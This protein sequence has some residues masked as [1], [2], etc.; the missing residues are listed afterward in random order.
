MAGDKPLAEELFNKATGEKMV[1]MVGPTKTHVLA[2]HGGLRLEGEAVVLGGFCASP[3]LKT[4]TIESLSEPLLNPS[5]S[6]DDLKVMVPDLEKMLEAE[7]PTELKAMRGEDKQV[8]VKPLKSMTIAFLWEPTQLKACSNIISTGSP[9]E[10]MSNLVQAVRDI[11]DEREMEEQEQDFWE[12]AIQH[13]WIQV[14]KFAHQFKLKNQV[15]GDTA[16]DLHCMD[17][18]KKMHHNQAEQASFEVQSNCNNN[19]DPG[20]SEGGRSKESKRGKQDSRS[21]GSSKKARHRKLP[22]KKK[23][24]DKKKRHRDPDSSDPSSSDDSPSNNSC[25][26]NLSCDYSGGIDSSDS[27]SS[28]SGSSDSNSSLSSV[29]VHRK[30]RK[31]KSKKSR[32]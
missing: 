26:E 4:F 23:R 9:M 24:A 17:Q 2:A 30:R 11:K 6:E 27:D 20:Q 31:N 8:T 1:I 7:L 14:N 21:T 10:V 28:C 16:V 18:M 12:L 13:L 3:P 15:E 32:G 19:S 29:S 5:L 22:A 25:S